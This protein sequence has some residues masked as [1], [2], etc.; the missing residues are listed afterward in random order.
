[1]CSKDYWM[2]MPSFGYVIANT[3]QRPV[4]YFSK[5]H[6]LTFLPDNVPLNQNTSIVFIYILERQH[7]VAMKLKPNV[8]VPPIANGWEEICVKNCK[9]WK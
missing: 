6:S 5:Y 9:L 7:F 4:H 1:P 3:F 2:S 8:P